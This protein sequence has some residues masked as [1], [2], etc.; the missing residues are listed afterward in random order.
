MSGCELSFFADEKEVLQIIENLCSPLPTSS[1]QDVS[2]VNIKIS[3]QFDRLTLLLCKYLEQPSLL[4]GSMTSIMTHLCDT[5]LRLSLSIKQSNDTSLSL[6]S[7]HS[8]DESGDTSTSNY[9]INHFLVI[10]ECIQL[11]CRVRGFKQVLKHFPHEVSH[12][13]L[14]VG[15]IQ[16]KVSKLKYACIYSYELLILFFIYR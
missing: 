14:C 11:L 8:S 7:N 2:D 10:C 1:N 4:N 13:E 5:L 6:S 16:Y 12:L 15:M 9:L 3:Q